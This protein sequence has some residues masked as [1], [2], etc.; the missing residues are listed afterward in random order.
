MSITQIFNNPWAKK[1]G[2]TIVNGQRI[3]GHIEKGHDDHL[4]IGRAHV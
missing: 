3:P 1:G 4:Q 2:M